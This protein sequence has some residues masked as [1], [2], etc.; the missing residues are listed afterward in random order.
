MGEW[1]DEKDQYGRG[2][3]VPATYYLYLDGTE[4]MMQYKHIQIK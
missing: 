4:N 3:R 1:V 2:I